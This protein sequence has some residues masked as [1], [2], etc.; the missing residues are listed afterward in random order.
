MLSKKNK[1]KM[2]KCLLILLYT[3]L[4]S[5]SFAQSSSDTITVTKSFGKYRFYQ[6]DKAMKLSTLA[7]KMRFNTRAYKR[8]SDAQSTKFLANIFGAAGGFMVGWQAGVFLAGN[9]PDIKYIGIGAG[10]IAISIPISIKSTK[11]A[12]EAVDIYNSGL[13]TS[14]KL[15]SPKLSIGI[16]DQGIGL[17][18]VF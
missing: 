1:W 16:A 5:T 14:S 3:I 17:K 11:Q 13:I 6:N 15:H 10:L 12:K 18:L 4:M 7:K 8:I 2:K 9:S